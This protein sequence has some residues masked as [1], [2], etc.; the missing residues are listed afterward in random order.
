MANQRKKDTVKKLQDKLASAKSVIL[1]DYQGLK[2]SQIQ[3]LKKQLATENGEF[4]VVK[5]T[6]FNIAAKN[7]N[8][9]LPK[10]TQ[11]SYPTAILIATQDEVS[12]LKKLVE[13]AKTATLP[14]IKFGFLGKDYLDEKGVNDLSKIPSK[15]VLIG[16][17]LSTLNGPTYGIVWAMKGNLIKLVTVLNNHKEKISK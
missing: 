12:P 17:L 15:T 4:I 11:Y 8:Y 1:T 13:F 2:V 6:L 14:K 10:D 16:R 5:N 9:N 7:S 3:D